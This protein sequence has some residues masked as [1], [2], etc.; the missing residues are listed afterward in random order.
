MP[1][2]INETLANMLIAVKNTVTENWSEVKSAANEFLQRRKER[3]S[4]LVEFRIN[5]DISHAKFMLRLEDEKLLFGAELHAIAIIT[6][7]IAQRAANAAIDVLEKAVKA[8][9]SAIKIK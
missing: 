5:G 2:D 3:L 9:I 1:F 6:K 8:A 7:A 4:L